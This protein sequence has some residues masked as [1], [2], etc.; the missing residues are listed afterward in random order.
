M[1][2]Y[3]KQDIHYFNSFICCS[4]YNYFEGDQLIFSHFNYSTSI[5][6]FPIKKEID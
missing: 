6:S 3:A 4:N 5:N 2:V 1:A